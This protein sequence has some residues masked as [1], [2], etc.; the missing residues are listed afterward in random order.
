MKEWNNHITQA[1]SNL[2][3]SSTPPPLTFSDIFLTFTYKKPNY[4]GICPPPPIFG[5][6]AINERE[7]KR[8]ISDIEPLPP[9]RVFMIMRSCE[10]LW[11]FFFIFYYYF[12]FLPI[13]SF[14]MGLPPPYFKKQ[15]SVP[16]KKNHVLSCKWYAI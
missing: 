6:Q 8:I 5:K 1:R 4:H 11:V 13:K 9:I 10:F 3:G 12:F 7:N 2:A 15:C 14:W 16:D